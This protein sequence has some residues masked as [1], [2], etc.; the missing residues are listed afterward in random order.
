M[1]VY[2]HSRSLNDKPN[3][4]MIVPRAKPLLERWI[5]VLVKV[6]ADFLAPY[7]EA[8]RRRIVRDG[9][10]GEA[11]SGFLDRFLEALASPEWPA[12]TYYPGGWYRGLTADGGDPLRVE[13]SPAGMA[14]FYQDEFRVEANGDWRVGEKL[15]V[16]PVR[17]F[18]LSH[19][20]FDPGLQ[21][22]LICYRL[23]SYNETRYVH[24]ESPPL[25]VARAAFAGDRIELSL[26]DETREPL[27]AESLRLDADE[28][29][30]CAVK[31]Q[32]LPALFEDNARWQ[33]LDKV[34][35]RQPGQWVLL[36]ADG[37]LPLNLHGPLKFPGGTF[38][39]G[40]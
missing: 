38:A 20:Q 35:E 31:S 18:F 37:E 26:N 25:R 12:G 14:R 34:E 33:L 29:L 11:F 19:L 3:A 36:T 32:G 9:G 4:A 16:D 40:P 13:F 10:Y 2:N 1:L 6:D 21:R 17:R 8:A 23:D 7:T 39:S 15:I 5:Y 22:Y 24:H 28:R 30:F 27:R